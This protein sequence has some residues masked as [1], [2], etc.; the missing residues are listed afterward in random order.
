MLSRCT[1]GFALGLGLLAALPGAWAAPPVSDAFVVVP[2]A[3]RAVERLPEGP[4]YWRIENARSLDA[5][6]TAAGPT[7]LVVEAA[8]RVWLFTLGLRQGRAADGELVAEIGPVPVVDAPRYLLR[9]NRAGGPPGA[10]SPVHS[11]PGSEAFHVLT[12]RLCQRTAHG[13]GQVEAGGSMNGHKPGIAMQLTSCGDTA[14]DQLVLFVVDATKPFSS[15]A[16]LE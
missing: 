12:G 1:R 16:R 4:L 8:G 10:T 14:L 9:V 11:H 3:E 6:R 5:A 2:V 13:T 15:P 7:S